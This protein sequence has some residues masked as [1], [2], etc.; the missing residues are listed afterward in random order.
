M[1]MIG[2]YAQ[3]DTTKVQMP[4]V[5]IDTLD[6]EDVASMLLGETRD[7]VRT[8]L[9]GVP[10]KQGPRPNEDIFYVYSRREKANIPLKFKYHNRTDT[11]YRLGSVEFMSRIG[12][13][14]YGTNDLQTAFW[15]E[16]IRNPKNGT[17]K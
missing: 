17:D 6:A 15:I 2:A 8:F 16:Y 5:Q 1:L 7:S 3:T 14:S 11:L 13:N 12:T 9:K 10:Y 4:E